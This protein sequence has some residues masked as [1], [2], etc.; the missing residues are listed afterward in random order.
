MGEYADRVL[1]GESCQKCGVYMENAVGYPRTCK[2]CKRQEVA[3]TLGTR[4]P[5]AT[6]SGKTNC[7]VCNKRVKLAGV[8][9]HLRDSHYSYWEE[10]NKE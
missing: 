5:P 10:V 1:E 6:N 8:D 9:S 3:T 4:K 7:P 2:G